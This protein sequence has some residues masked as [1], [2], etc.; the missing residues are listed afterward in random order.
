M[1]KGIKCKTTPPEVRNATRERKLCGVEPSEVRKL[2]ADAENRTGW[3]RLDLVAWLGVDQSTV[4][5]WELD[6][7]HKD[8]RDMPLTA[9]R[10]LHMLVQLREG[11]V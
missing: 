4:F 8:H 11:K 3:S 9:K 6:Y 10:L 5:R 7:D 1:P 2:F